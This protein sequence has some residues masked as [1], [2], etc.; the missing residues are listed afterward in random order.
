MLTEN[1]A[2]DIYCIFS[3]KIGLMKLDKSKIKLFSS[4]GSRATFGLVCLDLVK[5]FENYIITTIC[6]QLCH[7]SILRYDEMD[8][9][10]VIIGKK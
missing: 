4:I 3:K 2:I 1:I 5:E 10:F 8:H 6:C 7:I 9:H